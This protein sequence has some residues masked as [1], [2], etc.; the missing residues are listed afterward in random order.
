MLFKNLRTMSDSIEYCDD[1]PANVPCHM[2]RQCLRPKCDNCGSPATYRGLHWEAG[3]VYVCEDCR[4]SHGNEHQF[5]RQIWPPKNLPAGGGTDEQAGSSS[6]S[7]PG[8]ESLTNSKL[9][10]PDL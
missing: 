2:E 7:A 3:S 10:Q 1:C 5:M 4:K 6:P 8:G 9:S